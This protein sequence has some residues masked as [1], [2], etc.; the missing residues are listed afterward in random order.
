MKQFI[1]TVWTLIISGCANVAGD[2]RIPDEAVYAIS[3]R[4]CLGSRSQVLF[5]E[6]IQLIE[7][8]KGR[9]Y[10]VKETE[11]AFVVWSGSEDDL[12]YS[13]KNIGEINRM[14]SS[15]I[16]VT[17]DP[18]YIEVLSLDSLGNIIYKFGKPRN[19]SSLLLREVSQSELIE[20]SRVYP[21]G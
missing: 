9:F 4:K 10:K 13:V 16:V 8:V 11:T 14:Q 12:T 6:Q 20:Y 21:E 2:F 17:Q 5:C 3:E 7:L 15:S 19:F 1:L 18:D